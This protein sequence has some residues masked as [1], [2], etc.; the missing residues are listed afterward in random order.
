MLH[1]R[2]IFGGLIVL[3]LAVLA[4]LDFRLA[5]LNV[6]YNKE[7]WLP[8]GIILMPV[9]LVCLFY[10][11]RELLALLQDAGLH[12][13]PRSV[14]TSNLIIA[15][16]C[17]I[18]NVVQQYNL[19]VL[20]KT[21]SKGGWQWA[22]T[23]SVCAL[24]AFA[25]GLFICFASEM[26]RYQHPGGVTINLA[27]AVFAIAY[28]G[29]L[30]C[31]MILLHMAYGIGAIL[32]LIVVTKMGD[33]GAYT[34]GKM[35][36]RHKMTPGLSPGKTIE[37]AVGGLT[38]A[39]FGAWFWFMIFLPQLDLWRP[40]VANVSE[41]SFVAAVSFG[42]VIGLTGMVGDLAGS[43]MKRDS[44]KKDSGDAVPGFGGL[45]DIFDSLLMAAPVTFIFWTFGIVCPGYHH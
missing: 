41:T 4:Y 33:I 35:F 23:S 26:R 17:W 22:S 7:I 28:L 39:C 8:R 18:A 24:L 15:L 2:L 25:I 42:L 20:E 43:L 14:H 29:M 19:E 11:T 1:R 9:Y 5:H 16:V 38:F 30:S 6:I 13:S 37:G 44:C 31:F 34:V 12:P 27:G 40:Q 32:S 21:T 3:T 36:G 10:V 45:L